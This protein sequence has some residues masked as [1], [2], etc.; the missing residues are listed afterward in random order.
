MLEIK[1]TKTQKALFL[2]GMCQGVVAKDGTPLSPYMKPIMERMVPLKEGSELLFL[3]GGLC[4]LPRWAESKGH[5]V[6]VVEKDPDVLR[7]PG[8]PLGGLDAITALDGMEREWF[9]FILLDVWPHDP[10]LYCPEYFKKCKDVLV[11]NGLFSMNYICDTEVGLVDMAKQLTI[12]F[13]NVQMTTIYKDKEMKI[14]AQGVY[15]GH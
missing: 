9:D 4:I 7:L 11:K 14:P 13:N 10:K 3:G 12:V 6:C 8:S 2:N 1:E 15:F 5:N